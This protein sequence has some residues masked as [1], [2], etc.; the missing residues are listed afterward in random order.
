MKRPSFPEANSGA[1][2]RASEID[3]LEPRVL[4]S[5]APVDEAPD[6]HTADVHPVG[7][8][9]QDSDAPTQQGLVDDPTGSGHDNEPVAG[10]DGVT[11]VPTDDDSAQLNAE[12]LQAIASAAR[13]QWIESGVSAEQ[14]AALDSI[15]YEIS[16]LDGLQLG[17][18]S[19]YTI[20]IDLNAAGSGAWFVD[21]TPD[22]NEEFA[23]S[24][25]SLFTA[26]AGSAAQSRFDLLSVVLH[27]Q[28]HVIGLLDSD[29][30]SS[31]DAMHGDLLPGMRRLPLPGEAL[32][33]IPGSLDGPVFLTASGN[34][35]LTITGDATAET[36]VLK[37]DSGNFVYS[38][39][40]GADQIIGATAGVTSIQ[41]DMGG[42]DD[43]VTL[44][45][46]LSAF[47][48]ELSVIGNTGADSII[49]DA[50]LNLGA[51]NL[52]LNAEALTLNTGVT[53]NGTQS[54]TG[55]ITLGNSIALNAG[56]VSIANAVGLGAN[57][58]TINVATGSSAINGSISG[59]GNLY[60]SGAG[61]LT[62]G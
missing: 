59:S 57:D 47:G 24:G 61:T 32:G 10:G 29:A 9:S 30:D 19:G 55:N 13:Q 26:V 35:I 60:K 34:P 8:T 27:E 48:G 44:D 6:A 28:G 2:R 7:E 56:T 49:L 53:N 18:T 21:Q 22:A 46:S 4:F 58:L 51:N 25:D 16:D 40:G 54:F 36:L 15:S 42:G 37:I 31:L 14:L 45:A 5:G 41:I 17:S 1:N 50:S 43:S 62:L 3:V 23:A 20:T 33:A 39:N 52:T 38:L 11:L 12:T